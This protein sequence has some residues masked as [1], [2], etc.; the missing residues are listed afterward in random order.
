MKLNLNDDGNFD[1]NQVDDLNLD[2]LDG[3]VNTGLDAEESD[4]A[5]I[6]EFLQNFSDDSKGEVQ[7]DDTSWN[8]IMEDCVLSD[9]IKT[10]SGVGKKIGF[11]TALILVVCV[12]GAS[13][14]FLINY[15]LVLVPV[16]DANFSNSKM[17]VISNTY[18]LDVKA[19]KENDEILY[20]FDDGFFAKYNRAYIIDVETNY[21][22]VFDE[23]TGTKKSISYDNVK[24]R[25]DQ[26]L[27][28]VDKDGR[29]HV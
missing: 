12:I 28:K 3:N 11:I 5:E 2:G 15:K 18:R 6:N 17:S 20:S 24:F 4:A 16:E 19:L 23:A 14:F 8:S 9:D 22:K 13:L 1:I 26:S 21:V 10:K 7:I 27:V 29:A 25:V